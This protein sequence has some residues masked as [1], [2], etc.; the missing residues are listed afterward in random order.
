MKVLEAIFRHFI[1]LLLMLIVPTAIGAGVAYVLPRSYQSSASLWALKRYEIIGATGAESNLQAT[2]ADTQAEALTELL[3]SR[4][5]DTAVAQSTDLVSTLKLTA[6]ERSD[7]QLLGDALILNI[8]KYVIVQSKG[9]NLYEVS[10]TNPDPRVAAQVVTA[11]ITEFHLQGQGFSIVEGQRLL[12]GYQG[13][14]TQAQTDANNAAKDETSYLAAHPDIMKNGTSPLNDPQYAL[15]DSKRVQAQSTLESIQSTIATLNQEIAT[16]STG[17]DTFFKILD[18]AVQPDVATSRS[19][20]L[21]TAAGAGAAIGLLVCILYTLILVRRD[22]SLYTAL[23]V[24]KMTSFPVLMQVP[25]LPQT[26]VA[27]VFPNETR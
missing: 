2:P 7:P 18:P 26:S 9:Y 5:F 10:Y 27:L 24:Q 12:Q 6:Q 17:G 3:Q 25:Q 20:I 22:R 4:S 8:S 1:L 13:Q 15:L 14:L 19:K 11:V 23:D 16:Q 21:L